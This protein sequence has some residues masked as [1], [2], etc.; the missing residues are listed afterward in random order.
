MQSTCIP[1]SVIVLGNWFFASAA[2]A[3]GFDLL[4]ILHSAS[5]QEI[6]ADS[7]ID[8]AFAAFSLEHKAALLHF[9][10][11]ESLDVPQDRLTIRLV[12]AFHKKD[13]A[14]PPDLTRDKWREI[15][16]L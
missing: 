16:R 11:V 6:F 10:G 14:P 8:E 9:N 13:T 3:A 5:A 4:A 1:L 15:E 2:S 12:A 7:Y